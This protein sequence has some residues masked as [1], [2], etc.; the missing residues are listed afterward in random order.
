VIA[1]G[2]ILGGRY[3]I[4]GERPGDLHDLPSWWAV[5]RQLQRRV[6]VVVMAG[7]AGSL[8]VGRTARL[9]Y[10]GR[11]LDGGEHEGQAYLIIRAERGS[12]TRSVPRT[13]PAER[14]PTTATHGPLPPPVVHDDL[15]GI[16]PLPVGASPVVH[17]DLTG[18][19]PLPGG[20]PPPLVHDD[21]TGVLGAP[22][23]NPPPV[24]HADATEAIA[25]P[26]SDPTVIQPLPTMAGEG[27]PYGYPGVPP[28]PPGSPRP[29][30]STRTLV[31][32]AALGTFS[33]VLGASAW[34]GLS[35]LAQ[36]EPLPPAPVNAASDEGPAP[37]RTLPGDPG[38]SPTT[39]L[40]TVAEE[41]TTTTVTTPAPPP[42][43]GPAPSSSPKP[44]K[45]TTTKRRRGRS[46]FTL[47]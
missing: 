34:L 13:P 30:V 3:L 4:E 6:V 37:D 2:T 14:V 10:A 22:G 20:G 36:P 39:P 15:T 23:L 28:P 12:T 29:L 31:R 46:P 9:D 38:P 16:T 8:D 33:F 11:L 32:V 27:V 19:A 40:V 26:V 25:Q 18:I 47:D 17:D 1:G 7:D 5:D 24:V 43:A 35:V 44:T 45:T 41:V 21:A 42:T